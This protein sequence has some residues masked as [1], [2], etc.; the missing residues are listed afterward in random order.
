MLSATASSYGAFGAGANK[1]WIDP[2]NDLVIV[3]RWHDGNKADEFLKRVLA[4]VKGE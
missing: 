2:E 1:I 3:W 4:A